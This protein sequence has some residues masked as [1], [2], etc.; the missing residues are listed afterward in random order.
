MRGALGKQGEQP[1]GTIGCM[2]PANPG[3]L[4]LSILIC[5]NMNVLG[6]Q[7]R[8]DDNQIGRSSILIIKQLEEAVPTLKR[9][10]R[11]WKQ[12]ETLDKGGRAQAYQIPGLHL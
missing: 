8:T 4:S 1:V 11:D 9:T 3:T 6:M 7:Q 5:N 2:H 10:C 12:F